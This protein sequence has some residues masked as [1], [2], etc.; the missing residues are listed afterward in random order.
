MQRE[1]PKL[2]Q[3]PEDGSA[4]KPEELENEAITILD[5]LTTRMPDGR[6]SAKWVVRRDTGETKLYWAAGQNPML[7][8]RDWFR[9]YPST[10]LRCRLYR[11]PNQYGTNVW[12]MIQIDDNDMAIEGEG[13]SMEDQLTQVGL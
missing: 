13:P 12:K 10:P 7:Q 1:T 3:L 4:A 9:N 8:V 6:D 5:A 2:L 11:Q